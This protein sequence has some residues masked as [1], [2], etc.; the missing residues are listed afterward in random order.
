MH[1]EN[2]Y[3]ITKV[4][5]ALFSKTKVRIPETG[6]G[7]FWLVHLIIGKV[8]SKLKIVDHI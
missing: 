6:K 2:I 5:M 1:L 8:I 4:S 7:Y 3:V